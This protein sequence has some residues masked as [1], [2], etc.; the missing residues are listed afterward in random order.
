MENV[1]IIYYDIDKGKIDEFFRDNLNI[2][3]SDIKTSQFYD[4]SSGQDMEFHQV[5][6]L[7]QILSPTGT[8]SIVLKQLNHGI[9]LEDVVIVLSFNEK[10][11]EVVL[12]FPEKNL[13]FGDKETINHKCRNLLKHSMEILGQYVVPKIRIGYEPAS[14]DDTCL[15][16]LTDNEFSIENALQKLLR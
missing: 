2:M 3:E 4:N 5:N 13:F 6:S 15:I 8:G 12:N 7:E 9:T 16:E 14:D 10:D 11:G 1:E